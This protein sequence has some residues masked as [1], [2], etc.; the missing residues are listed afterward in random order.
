MVQNRESAAENQEPTIQKPRTEPEPRPEP[1][2]SEAA[3]LIANRAG[4]SKRLLVP[5]P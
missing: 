5:A 2:A 4:K 3:I 1:I